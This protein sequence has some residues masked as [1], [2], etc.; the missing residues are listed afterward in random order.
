MVNPM[1][2]TKIQRRIR[3]HVGRRHRYRPPPGGRMRRE[4]G[5][6][7]KE[8]AGRFYQLL[9]GHATTAPHLQRF[10]QAPSEPVLVVR[11]GRAADAL[12]PLRQV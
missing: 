9:S 7:R 12:P 4:L 5:R 2:H 10:G 11:F 8:L 1:R 3:E 6:V